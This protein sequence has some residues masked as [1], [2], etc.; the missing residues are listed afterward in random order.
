MENQD[1]LRHQFRAEQRARGETRMERYRSND[2]G[3]EGG[4]RMDA[5][6]EQVA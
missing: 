3:P 2:N 4:Y 5:N 6:G 1:S